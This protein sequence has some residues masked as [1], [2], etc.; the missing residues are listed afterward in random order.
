MKLD[1]KVALQPQ[2]SLF[3]L[4]TARAG[5]LKFGK[6]SVPYLMRKLKCSPSAAKEIIEATRR[7]TYQ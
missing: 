7:A 6:L 5:L 1:E 3:L 4:E 2:I